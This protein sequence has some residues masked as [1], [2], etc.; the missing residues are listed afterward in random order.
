MFGLMQRPT[1]KCNI[2]SNKIVHNNSNCIYREKT[3]KTK[4]KSKQLLKEKQQ[5]EEEQ[6]TNYT[7]WTSMAMNEFRCSYC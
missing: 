4:R 7:L 2:V 5:Q 1:L 6:K 3:T